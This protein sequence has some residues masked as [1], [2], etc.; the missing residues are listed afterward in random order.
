MPWSKPLRSNRLTPLTNEFQGMDCDS[1]KIS[2]V[3]HLEYSLAKDEYS[4]TQHDH[5]SCLALLARDRLVERRIETKQAYYK[6]DAK[7]IYYLSL[8]YLMG[9]SLGNSL[10][11]LDLYDNARTA[12]NELGYDFEEMLETEWDAGL[13]NGGLGRLASCFLDSMATLELPA[14]GYGLRYEYGIFFQSIRDGYQIETPDNW[15]RLGNIWEFPRPEYLFSVNF[16]GRV[17]Q[18][19]D[20]KGRLSFKWVDTHDVMAMAYDTPIPGYKNNTVNNLRLWSAKASREFDLEYFNHGDYIWAVSDKAF[21]ENITKILYPNDNVVQG[22]ELRLKQ[23]YFF[24]SA[25]LQDII[26]RYK[27]NHN[28]FESFHELVAIQLNDTH[29][30]I[31]IP[32]LMRLLMDFEGLNWDKAWNITI[33]TFAYTNHTILPEALE[34]WPVPLVENLLPRHMQIIYEINRRFLEEIKGNYPGNDLLLRELSI[35]YE[36]EPKQVRMANLAIIGSHSINGVAALHT[37]ILKTR[38]FKSFYEYCPDKFNNKTNGITQRRWLKL[39]NP[40]LSSFISEHIGTEWITNLDNLKKLIPFA[41]DRTFQ[42][43]W[44]KIK[45]QNKQ[46]LAE[47]IKKHNDIIINI[48]S[49][50]DIQVK[51]IHEYKR[52]LLNLLHVITLYNRIKDNPSGTFV[53]RTVIF[54][55]K[56]A[57]GYYIAKLII[58]LINSVAR[59]INNDRAT[60]DILNVLFLRNY[61]VSNA[62]KIIPAADLS[63]QISTAGT[64]ASGTGNMKFALNGALTIGTLDGANIEIMEEVGKENIFIFGLKANE[65]DRLRQ[66]GYNPMDYYNK[67]SELKRALDMIQKGSFSPSERDLFKPIIDLLLHQGDH[68]LLCADFE[69]YVNCQD[70]VRTAFMDKTAWGKMSILNTANMGKFSTDRTINEYARDI[71]KVNPVTVEISKKK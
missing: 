58:K 64:E 8:E 39:C 66:S 34:V 63:E 55:G 57:P 6:K 70:N 49:L 56:A 41:E 40:G 47:Y 61:A 20:D 24:V 10:I 17:E 29:P 46:G 62:E 1:L 16:Y 42:D 28:S 71:W 12:V 67:N 43:Q 37:E 38:V 3:D 35:I 32:E 44:M 5:Y 13:G 31:A 52:Q 59:V 25:T 18:H 60:R 51:R 48:D 33:N 69:S 36:G 19:K 23:E 27:V 21:S 50:F 26:R 2:F 45:K 22:K 11:N 7:R 15:L 14:M 9:R 65:A 30:A 53:P 54:A 4:A 68:Y